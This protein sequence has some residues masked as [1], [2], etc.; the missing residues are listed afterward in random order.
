P[1]GVAVFLTLPEIAELN[2][3]ER[4]TP[5]FKEIFESFKVKDVKELK[6][7][8]ENITKKMGFSLDLSKYGVTEDHFRYIA[9]HSI[10]PGRSDNN[11]VEIDV[12]KVITILKK[13]T[14]QKD[15]SL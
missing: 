12:E 14:S 3:C 7:G 1:H 5:V 10:I 9:E 13:T 11:P 4:T 8:L 2:Y 6:K 15:I